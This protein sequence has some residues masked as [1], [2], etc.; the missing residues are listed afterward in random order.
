MRGR[1]GGREEGSEHVMGCLSKLGSE[2]GR[3]RMVRKL[4]L[5]SLT[6]NLTS[7]L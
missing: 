1:E 2:G 6:R 4:C 7:D 3:G 5:K